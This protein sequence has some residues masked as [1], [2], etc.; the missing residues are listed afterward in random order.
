MIQ[1]HSSRRSR[2]DHTVLTQHPLDNV[3][4]Q[5][6]GQCRVVAQIGKG[7]LGLDH[8]ELGQVARSVGIFCAKR[9]TKGIN[10]GQRHAIGFDVELTRNGEERF[11]AKKIL[12]KID[13]AVRF[14][15]QVHQVQRRD[16]EQLTCAFRIRGGDDRR[17][18]PKESMIIEKTVNRRRNGVAHAGG[19][20]DHVG[21]RA[22]MGDL[23]QELHAVRFWG[24]RIGVW[25][26]DPA[27]HLDGAGLHFKRL[28]FGR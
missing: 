23:A 8:P 15:G 5:G 28:A 16:P 14:P 1:R 21:A 13:L 24:D 12:R 27:D 6:L 2:L 19:S 18:D 26:I 20:G 3:L 25:I 17:V 7:N 9:G 11:P 10:L 4:Q 22:Q